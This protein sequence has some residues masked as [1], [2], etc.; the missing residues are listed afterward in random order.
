MSEG[1]Q[2]SS[3]EWTKCF[4]EECIKA[5]LACALAVHM[6]NPAERAG[7]AARYQFAYFNMS[8]I[9]REHTASDKEAEDLIKDTIAYL[10]EQINEYFSRHL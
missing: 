1:P 5:A 6:T 10:Q 4:I 3:P 7:W 2:T 9:A 8:R